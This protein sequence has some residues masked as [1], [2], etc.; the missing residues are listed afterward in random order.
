MIVMIG[1]FIFGTLVGAILF[2]AAVSVEMMI[3]G[4]MR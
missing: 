2:A 3:K 4:F 1:D